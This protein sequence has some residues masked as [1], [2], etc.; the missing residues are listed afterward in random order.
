MKLRSFREGAKVAQ[1]FKPDQHKIADYLKSRLRVRGSIWDDILYQ[2]AGAVES[3]LLRYWLV[4]GKRKISDHIK[5]DS[6]DIEIMRT[7]N[8]HALRDYECPICSHSIRIT[9]RFCP[10]CGRAIAWKTEQ[11]DKMEDNGDR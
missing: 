7:S 5:D 9:Y 10:S 2:V 11:Q 1:S 3:Y 4:A 6:V 8:G